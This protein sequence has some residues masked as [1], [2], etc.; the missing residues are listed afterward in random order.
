MRAPSLANAPVLAG[1]LACCLA[2]S[3]CGST[4]GTEADTRAGGA[5]T[6]PLVR[7]WTPSFTRVGLLLA[8]EIA[9]EGPKGLL[10]HVATRP[11]EPHH[12]QNVETVPEGFRHEI[13]VADPTAPLEIRGHLD[14]LEVVALR[15]L[16]ILERPGDVRVTVRATGNVYYKPE[17]GDEVRRQS[18]ALQGA[19][20][21]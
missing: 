13:V 4:G 10:E 5:P 11:I 9:I 7:P 8:D 19:E 1:A 21:R 17:G 15:R 3:A 20:P 12:R 16:V 18:L 14:S 6:E 2:L